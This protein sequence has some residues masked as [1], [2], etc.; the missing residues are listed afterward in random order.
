MRRFN[1]FLLLLISFFLL[2]F[3]NCSNSKPK[4]V[5]CSSTLTEIVYEIGGGDQVIG[6]TS[7]C[8]FPEKVMQDKASGRVKVIGDFININ[9]ARIDSLKP[10][11]ILTDTNMQR[12]IADSLRSMGFTV[13]HYEPKSLDDVLACIVDIGKNIGQGKTANKIVDGMK[14]DIAAIRAETAA[15]PKT[16]VYMEINHMGPWTVGNESPLED[17]IEIAGGENIFGD[18]TIGVFV[19][20]NEEI[21]KRNPDIILS[22]IW[23][24][25]ELGGWKGITP[26]YEIYTRPEYMKTNAVTHSRVQYYDSALLKHEGPRQVLAIRKLA[27]LFHP[28]KFENPD[29]TIP[30]ELGWIK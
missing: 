1:S 20:T 6:A 13:L 30:W 5:S 2:T 14:S 11:L 7:F 16:K 21:V 26:L 3:Y 24:E 22:P 4:I 8:F 17:L 23:L 29:G 9:Y 15:L 25:A 10:D 28:D 27:Y 18:S 12:K 19:T